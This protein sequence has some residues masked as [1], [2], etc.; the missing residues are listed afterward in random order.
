MSL[1]VLS[2][3]DYGDL[4]KQNHQKIGL[5]KAYGVKKNLKV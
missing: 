1:I 5:I 4:V 3:V 2:L